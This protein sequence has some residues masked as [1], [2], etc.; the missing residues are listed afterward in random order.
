MFGFISSLFNTL[1]ASK[2]VLGMNSRNLTYIRPNN[3][4]PARILADN[5]IESKK[6]LKK[7]GI[8]IPKLLAQI[9]SHEELDIFDWDSLPNSFVLK[10]NS[11]LGGSGILIVYARKKGVKNVWIKSNGKTISKKDLF[12]HIHNILDGAFSITNSADIAFFEERLKISKELKP[13]SYKGIPDIR[14]IIYNKVPI[15]AMLRLPTKSS[16][17]KANLQQGGIGVGIDIATGTTTTAVQ[18]KSKIVEYIPKTRMLLR[19]IKI[20]Y[21]NEMLEYSVKA[22]EVSSLGYLGA[23]IAL[24]RD[25]GPVFLEL[26]AQPG[27]SIQIANMAGLKSRL[28][29]VE[30]L[31]IKNSAH[32][33]RVGKNLFGGE[34][35][36]ELEETSGK[37]VIGSIEKIMFRGI[38][39]KT[40]EVN[41]KID[42]GAYSTSIDIGLAKK[43]GFSNTIESFSKIDLSQFNIK[44]ENES[45]IK[46]EFFEKYNNKI[47]FL[48]NISVIFASSGSS[49][50]PVVKTSFILDNKK[51]IAKV[52]IVDRSN[53]KYPAII[54]KRNL[55]K[56]LID[57]SK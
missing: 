31:K 48:E 1:I 9:K 50:R 29:R 19:G 20:P 18:G 27:L 47:P 34:I 51:I 38:N 37:K 15:M 13:Y 57:V 25:N 42:T 33:V 55:H 30:G 7:N 24:D 44:P 45:S 16:D 52:N 56:F 40:I 53:L 10:P 35:E 28:K 41:A 36:Q 6:I 11:G 4:K 23:D 49:I 5:K 32:G 39:N 26:N 2:K 8:P 17:G 21:W 46:K 43:L 54:G 14:I 22:Q 3:L 12:N